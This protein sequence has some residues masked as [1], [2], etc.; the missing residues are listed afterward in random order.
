MWT[1]AV[2]LPA[3]VSRCEQGAGC[4]S[5]CYAT[6]IIRPPLTSKIRSHQSSQA[7]AARIAQLRPVT[8]NHAFH[9][10]FNHRSSHRACPLLTTASA[11]PTRS[12]RRPRPHA[13]R[14][15]APRP[16]Q[17]GC[18]GP[19]A[20]AGSA[21]P[22]CGGCCRW[23]ARSRRRRCVRCRGRARVGAAAAEARRAGRGGWNGAGEV[24][25]GPRRGW[26]WGRRG[27]WGGRGWGGRQ[28]AAAW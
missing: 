11:A 13:P 21:A 5:P 15:S 25:R 27:C 22:A 7:D 3:R 24:G 10:S 4:H 8:Q 2:L 18:S 19:R 28:G 1:G 6:L 14:P 17:P 23:S 16:R 20:C 9:Q 26:W 12:A